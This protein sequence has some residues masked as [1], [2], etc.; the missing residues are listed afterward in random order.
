[1]SDPD[2]ALVRTVC[3]VRTLRWVRSL[4]RLPWLLLPACCWK[5]NV[6]SYKSQN[7][8]IGYEVCGVA[9]LNAVEVEACGLHVKAKRGKYG[10]LGLW[11]RPEQEQ[12]HRLDADFDCHFTESFL[13]IVKHNYRGRGK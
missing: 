3:N 9:T 2:L 6:C 7:C 4:R 1:M 12:H 8:A 5:T 13:C 10:G 11:F